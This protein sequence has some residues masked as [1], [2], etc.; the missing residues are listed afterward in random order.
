MTGGGI[1]QLKHWDDSQLTNPLDK[2]RVKN[3]KLKQHDLQANPTSIENLEQSLADLEKEIASIFLANETRKIELNK[4]EQNAQDKNKRKN[5]FDP[6]LGSDEYLW[7]TGMGDELGADDEEKKI[8]EKGGFEST[9]GNN[10]NIQ[11]PNLSVKFDSTLFNASGQGKSSTLQGAKGAPAYTQLGI[12]PQVLAKLVDNRV[13]LAL[14]GQ[15]TS[16]NDNTIELPEFGQNGLSD[17]VERSFKAKF[18]KTYF[19]DSKNCSHQL[20]IILREFK[21][22]V[23]KWD[24]NEEASQELFLRILQGDAKSFGNH[25][26]NISQNSFADVWKLIQS[27]GRSN[28]KPL[29]AAKKIQKLIESP[30]EDEPLG[31]ILMNIYNLAFLS[32]SDLHTSEQI[33]AAAFMSQTAILDFIKQ[34]YGLGIHSV[35]SAEYNQFKRTKNL[36]ANNSIDFSTINNLMLIAIKHAGNEDRKPKREK[37]NGVYELKEIKN[38]ISEIKHESNENFNNRSLGKR[39]QNFP[40]NRCYLCNFYSNDKNH[41]KSHSSYKKCPFYTGPDGNPLTPDF[42]KNPCNLCQAYHPTSCKLSRN[43]YSP[44]RP[45]SY[46]NNQWNNRPSWNNKGRSYRSNNSVRRYQ[47]SRW[48]NNNNNNDQRYQYNPNYNKN[49]GVDVVGCRD[50]PTGPSNP[51]IQHF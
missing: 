15:I 41:P 25:Q 32:H 4:T 17:T 34:N 16:N 40:P 8:F 51:K 36:T 38:E 20:E 47:P 29:D 33:P 23:E 10:L 39:P 42:N 14:K 7:Q 21:N 43:N 22:L 9:F 2:Q 5:D 30:P 28:I 6:T 13:N 46:R 45:N 49:V 27:I 1:P 26:L 44:Q 12:T 3:L 50:M 19:K 48:G 31:S 11:K 35:V 18:G 24:L 37:R